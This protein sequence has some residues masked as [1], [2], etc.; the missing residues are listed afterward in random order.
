MRDR[1]DKFSSGFK[2][3]ILD[4]VKKLQLSEQA[5]IC[6]K[7]IQA[8]YFEGLYLHVCIRIK[9]YEIENQMLADASLKKAHPVKELQ[10]EVSSGEYNAL[11]AIG[12]MHPKESIPPIISMLEDILKKTSDEKRPQ[13]TIDFIKYCLKVLND[14][15]EDLNKGMGEQL[16]LIVLLQDTI[17]PDLRKMVEGAK[18]TPLQ[19]DIK[20]LC[21][22]IAF[23]LM[24]LLLP[25][26]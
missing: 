9:K 4:N 16:A 7:E 23:W 8:I 26:L 13:A 5:I 14:G 21:K 18:V 24:G 3:N 12:K 19:E 15:N 11:I 25:H 17:E 10:K 20:P 22:I 2:K 1:L 6:C